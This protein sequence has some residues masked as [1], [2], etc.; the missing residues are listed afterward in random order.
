MLIESR[1]IEAV[2]KSYNQGPGNTRKEL[3]G[4]S[5]GFADEYWDRYQRNYEKVV[6][7]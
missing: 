7:G 3:S 1:F 2:V 6:K 4:K 5:E